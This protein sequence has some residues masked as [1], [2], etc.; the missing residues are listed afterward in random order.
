MAIKKNYNEIMNDAGLSYQPVSKSFNDYQGHPWTKM[1]DDIVPQK[2]FK[3]ANL[4]DLDYYARNFGIDTSVAN[5]QDRFDKLTAQE[6]AQKGKEFQR[7]EDQYFQNMAAQNAQYQQ[8]AQNAISQALAAG[9]SR[10]M[11]FA[12]QFAAQNQLAEQN[13]SGALELALQRN[14]LKAQEAQAYTQNAINAE[15]TA[16]DRKA[17]ILGQAVADRANEVQR[18]AADA[19][20]YSNELAARLNNYQYNMDKVYDEYLLDKQLANDFWSQRASDM[21]DLEGTYYN[22]DSNL[23]GTKYNADMNYKGTMYNADKNHNPKTDETVSEDELVAQYYEAMH[24]ND[25]ATK[26]AL[27]QSFPWLTGTKEDADVYR[28]EK[29][30]EAKKS[31]KPVYYKSVLKNDRYAMPDGTT[32]SLKDYEA[33]KKKQ[34]AKKAEKDKQAKKNFFKQSPAAAGRPVYNLPGY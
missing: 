23:E 18:Y 11:Q 6:Y 22:A 33:W 5:L 2:D 12:N 32:L 34:D 16:Y 9:A 31:G 13:S 24:S 29:I 26:N 15:Q 14:D 20:L 30:D 17:N 25:W 7:S 8:G 19:T 28:K 3:D 10:G 27:E 1:Y 4:R 21:I